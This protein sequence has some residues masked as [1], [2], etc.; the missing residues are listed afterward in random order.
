MNMM[1]VTR[2][3]ILWFI[4]Y[5]VTNMFGFSFINLHD[6]FGSSLT[7]MSRWIYNE[8]LGTIVAWL[9]AILWGMKT[10]S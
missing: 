3:V 10:S 4:M 1:V 6:A 9:F 5:I 7:G 2:F 8:I